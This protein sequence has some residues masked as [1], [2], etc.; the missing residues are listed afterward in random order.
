M[1]KRV[2]CQNCDAVLEAEEKRSYILF[3]NTYFV[4]CYYC[5]SVRTEETTEPLRPPEWERTH[6]DNHA[7]LSNH[8]VRL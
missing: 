2:H 1:I 3:R 7:H 5:N 4:R 8:R 6:Q